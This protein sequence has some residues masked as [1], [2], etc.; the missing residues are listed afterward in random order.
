ME[1]T[2]SLT[3]QTVF[4]VKEVLFYINISNITPGVCHEP[5]IFDIILIPGGSEHSDDY[6][7]KRAT[8]RCDSEQPISRLLQAWSYH[9]ST[10]VGRRMCEHESKMAQGTYVPTFVK[11]MLH[12]KVKLLGGGL[13]SFSSSHVLI[14][15]FCNHKFFFIF[16][17]VGQGLIII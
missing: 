9:R 10:P 16:H 7:R 3:S 11:A 8:D 12:C 6:S 13:W 15:V 1:K 14:G 17:A 2:P 5:L 4:A